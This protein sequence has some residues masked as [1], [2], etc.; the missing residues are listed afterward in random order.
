M[1]KFPITLSPVKWSVIG[2]TNQHYNLEQTM[3]LRI[4]TMEVR[5]PDPSILVIRN[6][7]QSSKSNEQV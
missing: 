5:N 7:K 4:D 6:Q 2:R 1:N 3:F